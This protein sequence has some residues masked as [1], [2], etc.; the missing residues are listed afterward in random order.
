MLPYWRRFLVAV[1]GMTI[2]A[3]TQPALAA[4]MK[5]LLDGTF[6][7]R[8]PFWMKLAPVLIVGL[9]LIHGIG[10][11]VSVYGSNWLGN[12]VVFDL[13]EEMFGRLLALPARYFESNASGTLVSRFTFD[14]TQVALGTSSVATVVIKDGLSIIALMAYLL[15][16]N[17]N[18]TLLTFLIAPPI[19][20]VVGTVSRRLRTMSEGAQTAMGDL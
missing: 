13:R 2:A 16:L 20:L 14:A 5:P 18:L 1:A 15:Y 9:M 7:S 11:F 3:L 12:K 8:D 6:V 4:L 19:M 17:W 10:T